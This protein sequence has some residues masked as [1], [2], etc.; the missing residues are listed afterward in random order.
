MPEPINQV[1][2]SRK[3][4]DLTFYAFNEKG[5]AGVSMDQVAR[6][7]KISK[8]TIYRLFSSKEEILEKGLEELLAAVESD[9]APLKSKPEGK[10]SV[11]LFARKYLD[12][13]TR[14]SPLLREEIDHHL[15]HI[16][17]RI[18]LFENQV[19][20]RTLM[21]ILKDGRNKNVFTYPSPT[22]ECAATYLKFL[23]GISDAPAEYAEWA[24][25]SF[26]RGFSDREKKKKKK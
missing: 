8:K 22:K 20:K 15:P 1:D 10:N 12:Y 24:Y 21:T 19:F 14:I 6:E 23:K 11:Y 26:A 9:L 13:L 18:R 2:V 7:L 4:L 16:E 17:E 3:I 25:K 5:Y